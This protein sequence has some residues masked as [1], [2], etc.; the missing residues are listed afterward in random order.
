MIVQPVAQPA[1]T[2]AQAICR[3]LN[4]QQWG[5]FF[6]ALAFVSGPS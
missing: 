2:L 6:F 3:F 4:G 5:H 1:R